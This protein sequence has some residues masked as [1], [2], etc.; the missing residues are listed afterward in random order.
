MEVKTGVDTF[1]QN[2]LIHILGFA[3]IE[4]QRKHFAQHAALTILERKSSSIQGLVKGLITGKR[5]QRSLKNTSILRLI[6]QRVQQW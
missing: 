2:G 4:K 6:R 3:I 1:K 5:L